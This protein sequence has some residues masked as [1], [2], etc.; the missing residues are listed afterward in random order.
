M[1]EMTSRVFDPTYKYY[2]VGI[3]QILYFKS[4]G[5]ML[6]DFW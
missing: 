5:S 4:L 3:F 6:D 2:G 1:F